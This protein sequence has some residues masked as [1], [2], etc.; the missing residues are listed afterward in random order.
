MGVLALMPA[1]HLQ[2]EGVATAELVPILLPA[3]FIVF[4][5]LNLSSASLSLKTFTTGSPKNGINGDV[6]FFCN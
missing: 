5:A 6:V 3:H 2:E 1:N 4:S